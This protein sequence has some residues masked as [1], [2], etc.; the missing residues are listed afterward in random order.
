MSPAMSW[1]Q[2]TEFSK[3]SKETSDLTQHI[4]RNVLTEAL[5][6]SWCAATSNI[7]QPVKQN[8]SEK[9]RTSSRN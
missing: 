3:N 1:F 4:M 9:S 8:L 5:K 7:Q 6:A 2:E